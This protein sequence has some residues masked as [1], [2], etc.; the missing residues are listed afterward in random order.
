MWRKVENMI[1]KQ[2][3]IEINLENITTQREKQKIWKKLVF[4]W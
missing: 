4:P 3:C 1:N 2:R